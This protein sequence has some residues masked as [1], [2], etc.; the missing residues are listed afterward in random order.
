MLSCLIGDLRKRERLTDRSKSRK[1]VVAAIGGVWTLYGSFEAQMVGEYRP[2]P[3]PQRQRPNWSSRGQPIPDIIPGWH[4]QKGW[5]LLRFFGKTVLT[6]AVH[7]FSSFLI[8]ATSDPYNHWLWPTV[9]IYPDLN[10]AGKGSLPIF[11]MAAAAAFVFRSTALATPF[12]VTACWNPKDLTRLLWGICLPTWSRNLSESFAFLVWSADFALSWT[13]PMA[14]SKASRAVVALIN[15]G[16]F[17]V[18]AQS[19]VSS[20][21]IE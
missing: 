2:I 10:L 9:L 15:S 11:R 7:S 16:R 5:H 14:W 19:F 3:I 4:G 17:C 12:V 1:K 20:I 21:D 8:G 6:T 18:L 13:W